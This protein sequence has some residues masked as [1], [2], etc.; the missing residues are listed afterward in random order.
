MVLH[1]RQQA[2]EVVAAVGIN[3]RRSQLIPGNSTVR[4]GFELDRLPALVVRISQAFDIVSGPVASQCVE[5]HLVRTG[6]PLMLQRE[7]SEQYPVEF[8]AWLD[9]EEPQSVLSVP[10]GE[11]LVVDR[12]RL[13]QVAALSSCKD[14]VFAH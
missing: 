14:L 3:D 11:L 13:G 8:R 2:G 4:P 12:D 5:L 10:V 1:D 7:L 9:L 6:K